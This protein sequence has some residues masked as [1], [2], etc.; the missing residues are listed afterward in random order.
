MGFSPNHKARMLKPYTAAICWTLVVFCAT[1]LNAHLGQRGLILCIGEEGH[2][3]IELSGSHCCSDAHV[4]SQDAET[5]DESIN[6]CGSCTDIEMDGT[7]FFNKLGNPLLVRC[8]AP[9]RQPGWEPWLA[10]LT[11]P[12]NPWEQFDPPPQDRTLLTLRRRI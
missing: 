3:A 9:I 4:L 10:A 6:P 2:V 7:G 8:A 11:R 5:P 1:T 12:G